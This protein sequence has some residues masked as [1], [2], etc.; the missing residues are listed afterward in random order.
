MTEPKEKKEVKP[1]VPKVEY[2][3]KEDHDKS[4]EMILGAIANLAKAPDQPTR[5]LS[6]S[7]KPLATRVDKVDDASAE[8]SSY[9][10]NGHY[11]KIFNEYFAPED[12]FEGYLENLNFTIVVPLKLSNAIDA[13]KSYYKN[14]LRM[15]ALDPRAMEDG[16]RK[17]CQLVCQNLKYDLKKQLR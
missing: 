11:Q 6:A 14:D 13:H 5:A 3:T 7:D 15:K 9:K 1:K 4:M 10:L 16:F 12:G 2:V 17:W 8:A